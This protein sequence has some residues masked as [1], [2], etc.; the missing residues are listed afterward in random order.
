[1]KQQTSGN[2]LAGV[3]PLNLAKGCYKSIVVNV[4]GTNAG[5]A[6]LTVAQ[7]GRLR[8]TRKDGF[9][10]NVAFDAL[11]AI[12]NAEDGSFFASA[13]G[14]AITA[15]ARYNFFLPGDK[16]NVMKAE[17]SSEVQVQFQ[18]DPAAAAI[19][20][21]WTIDIAAVE[22][23]GVEKYMPSWIE[24]SQ[25][26]GAAGARIAPQIQDQ[27]VNKIFMLNAAAVTQVHIDKDGNALVDETSLALRGETQSDYKLAATPAY[28]LL[29]LNKVQSL[30]EIVSSKLQLY[31]TSAGVATLV[32]YY[33]KL[34]FNPARTQ[35]SKLSF[36]RYETA[37]VAKAPLVQGVAS[38]AP[39]T[40]TT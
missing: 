1:M 35:R 37:Q 38:L 11:V 14:G 3:I 20:A 32:M 13:I 6:T 33:Q 16:T 7:V 21:A 40:S 31:L 28:I 19:V 22:S 5:G 34:V 17:D 27:N 10:V 36:D 23:K 25:L 2:A 9:D 26:L 8:I 18:I 24:Y 4:T 39:G 29:N 12:N 30:G 15:Q